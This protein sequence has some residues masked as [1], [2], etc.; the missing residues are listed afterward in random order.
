M[1]TTQETTQIIKKSLA[2]ARRRCNDPRNNRYGYYGAKGIKCLLTEVDMTA[3]TYCYDVHTMKKPQLHRKKSNENYV[4]AN[5]M[6]IEASEHSR[7]T[8]TG[9]KR[10]AETKAKMSKAGGTRF[11]EEHGMARLTNDQARDIFN[12][13]QKGV[14]LAKRYG[15]ARSTI[16][17]IKTGQNWGRTCENCT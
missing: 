7:I 8:H 13:K 6:F 1:R 15:V 4:L 11:G 5:C 17:A 16:S 10:S 3:L 9:K 12:S 14:D 2:N